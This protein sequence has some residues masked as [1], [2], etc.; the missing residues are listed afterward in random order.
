[1]SFAIRYLRSKVYAELG[2]RTPKIIVSTPAASS[3]QMAPA[4]PSALSIKL[5]N[6]NPGTTV[7]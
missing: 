6:Y 5:R 7:G 3:S 1:M 4:I 2:R